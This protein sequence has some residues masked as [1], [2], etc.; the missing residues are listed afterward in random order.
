VANQ[1]QPGDS[2]AGPAPLSPTG[3]ARRRFAR[4]GATASGI[5]LTLQS[6]PAMAQVICASPSGSLSH[7][8]ASTQP[9]AGSTCQG[10]QPS[11]WAS[12]TKTWPGNFKKNDPYTK[13]YT[14]SGSLGSAKI[15]DVLSK[16]N[17]FDKSELGK[18]LAAAKLNVLS[19]KTSFQT[20]PMLN[21][22]WTECTSSKQCYEPTAGVS[23]TV[24]QVV[25]Y[26]RRTMPYA[27]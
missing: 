15:V 3:A 20:I 24:A 19:G 5:L 21:A 17:D 13:M 26:L 16:T 11:G 10:V 12:T 27:S 8:P 25:D 9:G 22:M 18:Y 14:C 4:N 2:V 6:A 7:G 1:Q 23:W